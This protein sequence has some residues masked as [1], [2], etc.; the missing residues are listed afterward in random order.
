[1]LDLDAD[2]DL[3]Y[4]RVMNR[5]RKRQATTW[6][7]PKLDNFNGNL[8]G[9]AYEGQDTLFVRDHSNQQYPPGY[10]NPQYRYYNQLAADGNDPSQQQLTASP[11]LYYPY[12]TVVE[13][14]NLFDGSD[15]GGQKTGTAS[16][17]AAANGPQQWEQNG[18]MKSMNG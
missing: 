8:K 15:S 14:D 9:T 4:G 18:G 3:P 1:M 12:R 17:A 10:F 6:S 16:L 5:R 7:G 11:G 13:R 2:V